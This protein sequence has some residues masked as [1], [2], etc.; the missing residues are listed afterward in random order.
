MGMLGSNDTGTNIELRHE[1]RTK[2]SMYN[3]GKRFCSIAEPDKDISK[4]KLNCSI[5]K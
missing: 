5:I 3:P 1:N 2:E 4:G